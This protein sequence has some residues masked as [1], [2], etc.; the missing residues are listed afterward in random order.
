MFTLIFYIYIIGFFV[1]FLRNFIENYN[2]WDDGDD[3]KQTS[4]TGRILLS[5]VTTLM[6][7]SIYALG[8]PIVWYLESSKQEEKQDPK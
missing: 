8:W 3:A 7:G 1:Y 4:F 5:S 6:I 2:S